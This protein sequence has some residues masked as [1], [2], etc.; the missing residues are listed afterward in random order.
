MTSPFKF[1]DAYGKND[2]NRFFGRDRETAQLYNAVFASNWVL[3][4]GASGTG[5][6]SLIDCGLANKFYDSDWYPIFVRRGSDINDSLKNA[7]ENAVKEKETPSVFDVLTIKN[8]ESTVKND[9]PTVKNDELTTKNDEPTAKFET[10]PSI[11]NALLSFSAA[12]A[13]EQVYRHYYRPVFLIFDQFEEVYILGNAAERKQF[14]DNIKE[15]LESKMAAKVIISIREEWIAYLNDFERV[16]PYLFDN[17][18]RVEK[19]D[20][21]NL[22]RIVNGTLKAANIPLDEPILTIRQILDNIRDRQNGVDLTN[23]QVYLDRVYRKAAEKVTLSTKTEPLTTESK[24]VNVKFDLATVQEVGAMQNVISD[25]LDEQLQSIEKNL[26]ERGV[27]N[28]KGIP[29]EILFAMISADGTKKPVDLLLLTENLPKNVRLT[30][31]DLMF[32]L[33]EFKRIR[34]VRETE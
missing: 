5:K 30:Q 9:E 32:C 27:T 7:L 10:L 11:D 21:R 18:L 17:R 19:P 26:I 23:L 28:A 29:I 14:F 13:V 12:T 16:V 31:D 20:D 24:P 4:Y 3:L 25:F 1:L 6:T 22:F 33:N 8:N 34:I 2:A 15:I